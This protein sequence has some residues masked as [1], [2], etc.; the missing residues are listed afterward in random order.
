MSFIFHPFFMFRLQWKCIWFDFCVYFVYVSTF[1]AVQDPMKGHF[2][3]SIE[4]KLNYWLNICSFFFF[5]FGCSLNILFPLLTNTAKKFPNWELSWYFS[6]SKR[7]QFAIHKT[8]NENLLFFMLIGFS[9]DWLVWNQLKK[10]F[11]WIHFEFWFRDEFAIIDNN[12]SLTLYTLN[13]LLWLFF[14]FFYFQNENLI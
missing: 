8:A 13:F 14:C 6:P 10:I 1:S 9:V 7:L 4:E 11:F 2:L 5:H 12:L 3:V